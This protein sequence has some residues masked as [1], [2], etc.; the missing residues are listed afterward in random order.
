MSS[1]PLLTLLALACAAPLGS[2]DRQAPGSAQAQDDAAPA[3]GNEAAPGEADR[4]EAGAPLPALRFGDGAGRTLDLAALKGRP[5]LLN[6]WA[7]WCAPCVAEMPQL[8]ALAEEYDG[9]LAVVTVSQD[10][11][12]AKLVEPFFARARL[13][14][15]QPWLDPDNRLTAALDAGQLPTTVLYD[16]QG[17]EV[18]RVAGPL[19]WEG[20]EA[21]ALID[22]AVAPEPKG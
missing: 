22:E 20:E 1:R 12:G 17:R 6:L 15:L 2:C 8:D 9:R 18:W 21:A 4:T 7:T 13:Q 14:R 5:V 3:S 10:I 16:A 11:G 19:D